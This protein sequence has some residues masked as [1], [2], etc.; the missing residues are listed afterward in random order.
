[1]HRVNTRLSGTRSRRHLSHLC[2]GHMWLMVACAPSCSKCFCG[3]DA[4]LPLHFSF[5]NT[6]EDVASAFEES[7][8]A[9]K[10]VDCGSL[11]RKE[12]T[13]MALAGDGSPT[14]S[15]RASHR[16]SCA[17][18]GAHLAKTTRDK[19]SPENKPL[20][21]VCY[22]TRKKAAHERVWWARQIFSMAAETMFMYEGRLRE[23]SRRQSAIV[24]PCLF[25]VAS[26]GK[27]SSSFNG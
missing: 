16:R 2:C 3:L 18:E 22:Q 25:M 10:C 4:V 11:F 20:V 23:H 9:H 13:G 7:L 24:F 8:W 19:R 6:A 15:I 27:M 21:P 17:K 14:V 5:R 1:V 12:T 26:L